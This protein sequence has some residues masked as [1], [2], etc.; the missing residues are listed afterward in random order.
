MNF[1]MFFSALCSRQKGVGLDGL[2]AVLARLG[3]PQNHY[4]IIHVAGTNGKG[5]VCTLLA[6]ALL[7]S[8]HTTGLFVSPH[9]QCPTERIQ[10]NGKPISKTAFVRIVQAVQKAERE[11][12]NF[13]ALLTAAA[14]CYFAERKAEYVVLETGLGGRK[15]PTNVCN[16]VLSVI[17]SVGLDHTAVLGESLAQ[18]AS[19]KAG[20]IKPCVPVLCG[21]VPPP[22]A[23]IIRQIARRQKA[24]LEFIKTPF[25]IAKTDW[26][27]QCLYLKIPAYKRSWPLHLLGG[28]QALNA[29]VVYRAAEELKIPKAALKKAFA[30][31]N[32]PVRF[33]IIRTP[34]NIFI[35][36]GAHNPQ[37]VENLIKRWQ[38]MPGYPQAVLVCGFMRDKD[39]PQMMRLLAPHFKHVICTQAPCNRSVSAS[40]LKKYAPPMVQI[41]ADYRGALKKAVGLAPCVVC[42]G[43]F[44]LAGAVRQELKKSRFY[45][46]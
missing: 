28:A 6:Q 26:N 42:T 9:V 23:K 46:H 15:D 8:G 11:K 45:S 18:I 5:S 3:S 36:D 33:E 24:P 25:E 10:L 14:L 21:Q 40:E 43:S 34:K 32:I 2:R 4:K 19:E 17:T 41:M 13:F 30:L 12:L 16:S 1:E 37:A 35:L 31:V 22:A 27:R 39:Y 20:I 44:Y 29:A 7:Q 38:K